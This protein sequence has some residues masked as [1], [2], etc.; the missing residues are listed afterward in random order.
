MSSVKRVVVIGGGL[1]GLSAAYRI[2]E[3]ARAAQ[4]SVEVVVLEAKD[5]VGGAIW[6]KRVEG[7]TLEMGPDSF[8]TNKPWAVDLCR[9]LGL[10]SRLVGTDGQHRRSF[11]V[12]DGRLCP[13]PEGFVL[14]APNRIGPILTTPILSFK[15]K[16]RMLL[17]LVLP[18]GTEETDESLASFV[19]RRFGREALD[20]LVQPLVGGIYTAD[21]NELSVRATLPQFLE[22]ERKHGSLILGALRQARQLRWAE[23]HASGARYGM[24]VTLDDGMDTLTKAL[25]AALPTGTVRTSTAVRRISR[26]E[27]ASPWMV[28]LLDGPSIEASAVV[29]ATEAHASARLLDGVDPGLAL[30]LRS[31]PYASSVIVNIAYPR[32]QV[33]HPLDG[34]GVVVPAIEKRSILAVSFLSVKFPHRAPA[35]TV[36]M[37][38]FLG[39]ATQ[40]ELCDLDDESLATIVRAELY[41]LLGARGAPLLTEVARHPRAMP[42]YTLGHLERV[43]SIRAQAARHPLLFLAG[44]AFDGVGIPDTIRAALAAADAALAALTDAASAAA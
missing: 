25:A 2:V 9:A 27:P 8:I 1:S 30:Q 21:P 36:L 41:E 35:G 24:F 14:M 15:G 26:N 6:T 28:E 11:V 44:N 17:D 42:Q 7:F 5:R 23:K 39:G 40:P 18:R 13:V 32:D 33:A 20:R 34:F 29:M 31:I 10:S 3:R 4:K 12:R 43:E 22:M 37:R 16:M 19:K 38:V